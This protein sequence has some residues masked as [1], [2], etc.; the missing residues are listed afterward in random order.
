MSVRVVHRGLCPRIRTHLQATP[1]VSTVKLVLRPFTQIW[2]NHWTRLESLQS[3]ACTFY[4][5]S[6]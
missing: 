2:L 1:I 5:N 3:F 4:Q 6:T